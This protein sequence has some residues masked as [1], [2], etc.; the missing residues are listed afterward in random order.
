MNV[1]D[2]STNEIFHD[3][4]LF[5]TEMK[6]LF[7]NEWT[8]AGMAD[9]LPEPDSWFTFEMWDRSI[10][11]G[12]DKRN[13]LHAFV[14]SCSHRGTRLCSPS[15][16]GSGRIRC[17]YHGW[18]Y[19]CS[20]KLVA[21]SRR[22][23]LP[24]FNTDDYGLDPL[25]V[26]QA[27]AFIFVHAAANP[28][29]PFREAV[30]A[31]ALEGLS[32]N[33]KSCLLT[34]RTRISG[35]WKLAVSGTLEDYHV[36][37]VHAHSVN[38]KR[39]VE[40]GRSSLNARGDSLLLAPL[41]GNRV[42][43]F[44]STWRLAEEPALT[45]ESHFIFPNLVVIRFRSFIHVATFLPTAVGVTTR[46]SRLYDGST[47]NGAAPRKW[48]LRRLTPIIRRAI[49]KGFEEDRRAVEEAHIGTHIG[50][51]RRRGPSHIEELRVDHFLSEISKRLGPRFEAPD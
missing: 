8:F 41:R 1:Q 30:D 33:L 6:A 4:E 2:F 39:Q 14:N 28:P 44:L 36:N 29:K 18:I 43:R 37:V 11:V 35:N 48:I 34:M 3:P 20:G 12:R 22:A 47:K 49:G 5:E 16:A 23:G 7:L 38:H 15:G 19:D 27:G 25:S 10:V 45:Y 9:E 40:V 42:Q 24:P 51:R 31:A 21:A 13:R 50:R 46:I 32:A 17:P 26:A